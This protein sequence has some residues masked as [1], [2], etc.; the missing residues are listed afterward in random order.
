MAV[1]WPAPF[2][3]FLVPYVNSVSSSV[4][5]RIVCWSTH[6][7]IW[8][9]NRHMNTEVCW[10]WNLMILYYWRKNLRQFFILRRTQRNFNQNWSSHYVSF[11][12]YHELFP[13]SFV[14]SSTWRNLT[15]P[16]FFW[17]GGRMVFLPRQLLFLM[18]VWKMQPDDKCLC[19]FRETVYTRF[20]VNIRL[21]AW[22]N[23]C[24]LVVE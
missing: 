10:I 8:I 21:P 7:C 19:R 9:F 2:S 4:V 1:T 16:V 22:E 17:E 23:Y 13:V 20:L 11:S 3:C 5:Q 14:S 12:I 18:K 6:H 24:G 15:D